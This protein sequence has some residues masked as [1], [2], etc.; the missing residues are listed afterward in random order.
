MRRSL[1]VGVAV[2]ATIVAH[3]AAHHS[4]AAVYVMTQQ[5]TIDGVVTKYGF[6]NPHV[7]V[8]LD[9]K[10]PDGAVEQWMAEGGSPIVLRRQGWKGQELKPGDRVQITGNPAR[11]KSRL[12]H[13]NTIRLPNGSDLYG[14]DIDFGAVDELR[15]QRRK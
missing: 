3:G 12:I 4:A 5:I 8:Y 6:V 2:W 14:E 9:V 1:F 7:R 13:W 15:Q 11:D 10:N